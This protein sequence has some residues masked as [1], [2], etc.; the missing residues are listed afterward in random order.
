MH[1]LLSVNSIDGFLL[2]DDSSVKTMRELDCKQ[3]VEELFLQETMS[4]V[5]EVSGLS[6][7]PDNTRCLSKVLAAVWPEHL[8]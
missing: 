6:I 3:V 5:C 7:K 1:L 8:A 2:Y 4:T